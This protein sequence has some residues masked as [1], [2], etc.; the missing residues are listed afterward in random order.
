MLIKK[1]IEDTPKMP[2]KSSLKGL[3]LDLNEYPLDWEGS[4]KEEITKIVKKT[5][6]NRY[7]DWNSSYSQITTK[8]AK[9]LKCNSSFISLGSGSSYLISQ[10]INIL[11]FEGKET[12]V[13]KP[14]FPYINYCLS[15]NK[16]KYQNWSL[17]NYYY[18]FEQIKKIKND[19]IVFAISPH[20]PFG[21]AFKREDFE[22][23]LKEK[24][25]ILFIVDQAYI[26]FS[27]DSYNLV[28]LT[29]KYNNLILIR[30]FS[31]AFSAAAL[32]FGY[33][34][35][36]SSEITNNLY[37]VI[38]PFILNPL[39]IQFIDYI[40]ENSLLV[41]SRV[42]ILV[43]ERERVKT[44]LNKNKNLFITDSQANFIFVEVKDKSRFEKIKKNLSDN[45]MLIHEIENSFRITI[46]THEDNNKIISIFS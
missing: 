25:N 4:L 24:K 27:D 29:S 37:K 19:A 2:F 5:N 38:H 15:L 23:L 1:H 11:D 10:L 45:N 18:N 12:I 39:T 28:K 14:S 8:L 34:I 26:E 41:Q 16:V 33:I 21:I 9:Q 17:E 42:K 7:V 32:R 13:V 35:T 30:T 6:W 20:N 22:I 44:N 43:E 31:K 3:R 40:L 46:G 36:S